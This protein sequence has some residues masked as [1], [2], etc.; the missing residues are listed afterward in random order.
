MISHLLK[1]NLN[2]VQFQ[3]LKYAAFSVL[4]LCKLIIFEVG[5]LVKRSKWKTTLWTVSLLYHLIFYRLNDSLIS[6]KRIAALNLSF[7]LCSYAHSV[8]KINTEV[9]REVRHNLTHQ[10]LTDTKKKCQKVP[11]VPVISGQSVNCGEQQLLF[12]C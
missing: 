10:C 2:I 7:P 11:P 3:L 4:C 8:K 12:S 6:R 5:C 9:T 1:K